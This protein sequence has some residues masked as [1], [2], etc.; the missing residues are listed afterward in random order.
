[1]TD[2]ST[3]MIRVTSTEFGKEVGRYQDA[4]LMQPVVVTRNGRD[5]TVMISA[6]EYRRL[7]RRD[8]E[9]MG[10]EDFTAADIEAVGRA[11][12][13]RSAEAFNPEFQP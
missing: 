4:A 2:E 11:E 6:D 8:R 3:T 1:M 13:S 10:I 9:V 12:P 7:K 5:R